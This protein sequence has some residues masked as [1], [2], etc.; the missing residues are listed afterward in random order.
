M[1]TTNDTFTSDGRHLTTSQAK[2][3]LRR[4]GVRDDR[5][6]PISRAMVSQLFVPT[7]AVGKT[8]Y[9][10]RSPDYDRL[11]LE[12]GSSGWKFEAVQ[13]VPKAHTS[14]MHFASC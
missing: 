2:A 14:Q 10:E 5:E 3:I 1:C 7:H 8:Q 4:H 6:Y 11:I 12:I 13:P 9:W